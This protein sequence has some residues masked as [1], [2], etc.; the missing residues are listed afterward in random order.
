[1]SQTDCDSNESQIDLINIV[2]NKED[3]N[4]RN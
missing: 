2:N 3:I 4:D 1:M